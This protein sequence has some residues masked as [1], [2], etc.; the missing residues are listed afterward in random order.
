[1]KFKLICNMYQIMLI[2]S[3]EGH[4][5]NICKDEGIVMLDPTPSTS[6]KPWAATQLILD[7]YLF[8]FIIICTHYENMFQHVSIIS[9]ST[10]SW[11]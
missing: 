9:S 8:E 6:G 7:L 3:G 10:C 4:T 2:S 1:M 5:A 11:I